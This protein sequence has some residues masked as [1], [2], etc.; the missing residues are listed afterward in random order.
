M[1]TS[2]P[3]STAGAMLYPRAMSRESRAAPDTLSLAEHVC[4]A[5]VSEGIAHGWAV[6]AV[7]ARDGELGRIWSLSRPLTYRAIDQLADKELVA[8]TGTSPGRGR[9][10][11]TVAATSRGRRATQR[12]LDAPVEHVRDVRTE[13]LL[14]LELRR[15]AGLELVP[16]LDAQ[17][18]AFAHRIELLTSVREPDLVDLWRREH[19]RAVRRFLVAARSTGA[20]APRPPQGGLAL[21]A[22]NQLRATVVELEL[23][24]VLC[25]VSA[26]LADGQSIS[27]TVTRA[28]VD[29][30]DLVEG[31]DVLVVFKA[32][33]TMIAKVAE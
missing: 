12:W 13:L 5:L 4:L 11:R 33:E 19:A 10:R 14:K 8:R 1:L 25:Q 21:S 29:E 6:G 23:G 15:R 24:D 3:K 32:T 28:A 27:A 26:A 30:L 16:L 7:L 18:E 31:D 17:A 2:V 22:R 9:D 20:V